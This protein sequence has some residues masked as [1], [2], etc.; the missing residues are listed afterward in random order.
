[1]LPSYPTW[2][3][4]GRLIS[5]SVGNFLVS[6][7]FCFN[8]CRKSELLLGVIGDTDSTDRT[9]Q[10]DTVSL[11][12]WIV[13]D[14]AEEIFEISHIS[15]TATV[16]FLRE[17]IKEKNPNSLRNVDARKLRIWTVDLGI[18][19]AHLKYYRPRH[20]A[21]L[22]VTILK[23]V[24]PTPLR[25]NRLHIIIEVPPPDAGDDEVT[26][27]KR[28]EVQLVRIYRRSLRVSQKPEVSLSWNPMTTQVLT[29]RQPMVDEIKRSQNLVMTLCKAMSVKPL[30]SGERKGA[31]PVECKTENA[32]S[33]PPFGTPSRVGRNALNLR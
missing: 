3:S 6:F 15:P 8:P 16:G 7:F 1:M 4:T 12:C 29:T 33:R 25:R 13:G 30:D 32:S 24:I 23:D 19:A 5:S 14:D 31:S 9:L 22:P 26:W 20:D 10:S 27:I 18:I 17:L 11:N 2:P 21:L 28:G